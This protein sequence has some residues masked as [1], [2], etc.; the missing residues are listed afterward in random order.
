MNKDIDIARKATMLPITEIAKK[1]GIDTDIIDTYGKY[2]A[3]LPLSL[4]DESKVNKNKLILV[5]AI[6][7][8]PAG[9]GKTTTSIGL[10]QAMNKLGHQ[11]TVVLRE[12]SLGPVFGIKG[13]AAGGGHSQV[14]PMEDINLHFTGDLSAIEKAHNLLAALIDNNIQSKTR[15]LGLDPRTIKWKRVMDMNERALRHIVIGLGGETQGVPRETGFD[16]TAASEIMAILCLA[17]NIQDLKQ[18]LGNIF[19]GFTY[20][21]TPIYARDLKANGA[22]AVLLK[23]AIK[24]NLVQTLEN[25]PAII[26][27]GPFA[28]IAQGTNSLIATKMGLSLSDFIVTEAGFASE[29]GA[30]KFF[31]IKAQYGKLTPNAAVLVATIRALKYHGG[32]KLKELDQENPEAV[33]IGLAN[34][35]KHIENL[36]HFNFRPIVAINKFSSDTDVEIKVITDH[37]DEI[38]IKYALNDAWAQGGKGALEL[39]QIVVDTANA[40]TTCF[41]PLYEFEWSIEKKIETIATKLYGAESVEYSLKAR[42]DLQTIA[43]LGLDKL[44]VCIAKTQKSLSDKPKLKNRPSGFIV[45]IREIE[46]AA[47]AGFVVPIAGSIMR[48]PGLPE[49]PSSEVIDIDNEGNITGLF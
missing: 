31:D 3:K 35:D 43:D 27:G 42:K 6:T 16:I 34:L 24:P 13:G 2:K 32:A 18:K 8:T 19:I 17:N 37:L 29:L 30:E 38:K 1:L 25:T 47:G 14:I 9:E 21:K 12:P 26:H 33:K 4:I 23:D 5:T 40:C 15:N 48:M 46:I 44:P 10:A 45:N 49:V 20:D 41:Q 36:K 28:N 39:A 11:T 22:M 7:P